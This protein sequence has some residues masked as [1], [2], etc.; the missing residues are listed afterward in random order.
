MGNG[1]RWIVVGNVITQWLVIYDY[2]INDEWLI[3][4]IDHVI[5][6]HLS[7]MVIQ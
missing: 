5:N 4:I 3:M 6:H 1:K 7:I 2:V